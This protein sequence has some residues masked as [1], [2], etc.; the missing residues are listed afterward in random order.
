MMDE[1]LRKHIMIR[2]MYAINI[3]PSGVVCYGWSAAQPPTYRTVDG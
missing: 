2:I 1:A 3:I